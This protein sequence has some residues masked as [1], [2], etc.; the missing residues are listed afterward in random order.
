MENGQVFGRILA[1][2]VN[3][4]GR[5]IVRF[6]RSYLNEPPASPGVW[7]RTARW[8]GL[9]AALN[10][11]PA[12]SGVWLRTSRWVALRAA[13]WGLVPGLCGRV[14]SRIV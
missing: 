8:V 11:P 14:I 9:R 13:F 10:E 12:A 5:R 6:E 4:L 3:Q 1:G 7:L 2:I